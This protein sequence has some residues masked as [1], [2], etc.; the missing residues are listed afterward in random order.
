MPPHV[1]TQRGCR[2]ILSP[3]TI[4]KMPPHVSTQRGC[5][6]ILSPGTISKVPP[7]V[8]TQR[9]CRLILSP[10]TIF[11]PAGHLDLSV[12]FSSKSISYRPAICLWLAPLSCRRE[13]TCNASRA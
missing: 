3:G 1:S 10:G 8:S 9:G 5:R 11:R 12:D 2:L 13:Q 4:L 6:L 7:H